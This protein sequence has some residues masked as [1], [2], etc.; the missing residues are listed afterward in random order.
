MSWKR[1][2]LRQCR[3]QRSQ[4]LWQAKSM[5]HK[6]RYTPGTPNY[7]M[8]CLQ[9]D[10]KFSNLGTNCKRTQLWSPILRLKRLKL[11]GE[12]AYSSRLT[13][14]VLVINRI[15]NLASFFV[16]K[17]GNKMPVTTKIQNCVI[18]THSCRPICNRAP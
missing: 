11:G 3:S 5:A 8:D 7:E 10:C 6:M 2:R 1:K 4:Q 18:F 16:I 14:N 17:L 9:L 13:L 12:I 15:S